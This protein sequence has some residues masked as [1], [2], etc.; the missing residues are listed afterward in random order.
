MA[1]FLGDAGFGAQGS[2]EH[3]ADAADRL[4]AGARFQG[5]IGQRRD[6][7]R[8]GLA[9]LVERRAGQRGVAQPGVVAGF[10]VQRGGQQEHEFKA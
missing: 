3:A 1:L 7:C 5:G 2:A 10:R 8:D 6:H 9:V 4:A